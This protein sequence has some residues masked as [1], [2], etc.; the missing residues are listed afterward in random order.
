[1]EDAAAILA[2]FNV[3]KVCPIE[4]CGLIETPKEEKYFE[5]VSN[6]LAVSNSVAL[7]AMRRTAEARGFHAE[8]RDTKLTGDASKVA[9]MVVDAIGAAAPKTVLL[10]GGETT[11]TVRGT[12][13]GGRNLTVSATALQNVP[14]DAEILSLASD[15][16][17]HSLF[18]GAICD[19]ATKDALAKSGLDLQRALTNNDTYPLFQKIGGYLMTGDTGS[20]VSDLIIALKED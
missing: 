12:G 17:D 16:R 4:N 15:G 9:A 2:K 8:I 1:M 10:W 11:V 3:L 13:E 20:N 18:A 5:R 7:E 14:D 6:V 19:T